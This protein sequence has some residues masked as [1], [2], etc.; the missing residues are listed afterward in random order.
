MKFN[1]EKAKDSAGKIIRKTVGITALSVATAG[2]V[3]NP[4]D[5]I[6]QNKKNKIENITRNEADCP[7]IHQFED[8]DYND[9]NYN[10]VV[11]IDLIS[12]KQENERKFHIYIFRS[13][14]S[15]VSDIISPLDSHLDH[16]SKKALIDSYEYK[17]TKGSNVRYFNVVIGNDTM[18]VKGN[19]PMMYL[20]CNDEQLL[21]DFSKFGGFP[22]YIDKKNGWASF[23]DSYGGAE[24]FYE[25]LNELIKKIDRFQ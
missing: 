10:H 8:H 7:Q 4:I 19:P 5:A 12:N 3:S 25:K 23:E 22:L 20:F 17:Y 15:Y 14:G 21:K 18:R 1:F 16:F 2:A 9:P 13:E 6:A 11:N 24:E